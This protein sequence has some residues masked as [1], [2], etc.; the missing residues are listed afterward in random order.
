MNA[1]YYWAQQDA[2]RI[3]P[4]GDNSSCSG[5]YYDRTVIA[6]LDFGS[7]DYNPAGTE[8][9]V[10][11]WG[12]DGTQY[13]YSYTNLQSFADQ[14][15][16][17]YYNKAGVCSHMTVV[18]GVSNSYECTAANQ[19]QSYYCIYNEG[20][21][22]DM[23]VSSAENTLHSYAAQSSA[24]ADIL[25]QVNTAGGDDIESGPGFDTFNETEGFMSGF[26]AENSLIG[27]SYYLWDYGGVG[28][29]CGSN[30]ATGNTTTWDDGEFYQAAW[31]Y[32]WDMPL[33]ENYKSNYTFEGPA[34]GE[35]YTHTI[36]TTV[37]SDCTVNG[38]FAGPI[39][40]SG[41]MTANVWNDSTYYNAFYG[42]GYGEPW[43]NQYY[44]D[45]CMPNLSFDSEL[46]TPC[47]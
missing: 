5:S 20:T 22:L 13:W 34:W 28:S 3:D 25:N 37:C 15:A 43:P 46:A 21:G 11:N 42:S 41:V 2:S 39:Q 14:Y 30:C 31:G 12:A 7:P 10:D 9:G 44:F 29:I 1:M 45:T 23:A 38:K 27:S 36:N 16:E 32:G 35:I 17:T 18:I 19:Q 8:W 24:N 47:Y 26:T 33:P 40:F 6:V 4:M